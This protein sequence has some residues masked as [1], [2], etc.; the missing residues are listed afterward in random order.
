MN[1]PF[2][3][4][5]SAKPAE[6]SKSF[7]ERQGSTSS[8]LGAVPLRTVGN[9]IKGA[10]QGFNRSVA[11]VALTGINKL[12]GL[13]GQKP[14][15]FESPEGVKGFAGGLQRTV[16]G[17]EPVQDI[18]TRISRFKTEHPKISG[19]SPGTAAVTVIGSIGLDFTGLG[20]EE[21]AIKQLAKETTESGVLK[22]LTKLKVPAKDAD[23]LVK[24]LMAAKT[25]EEVNTILKGTK[26]AEGAVASEVV[27]G[28]GRRDRFRS[29]ESPAVKALVDAKV[30][31][32]TRDVVFRELFTDEATG[33]L[34]RNYYEKS[35]FKK[36]PQVIVDLDKFKDVNSKYEYQTGDAVLKR[37]AEILEK[38]FPDR[39]IRIGGEEMAVDTQ[40]LTRELVSGKLEAANAELR[41]SRFTSIKAGSEPAGTKFSG[42]SFT[43]GYGRDSGEAGE[44]LLKQKNIQRGK[45]TVDEFL[46]N[47]HNAQSV[48]RQGANIEEARPGLQAAPGGAENSGRPLRGGS[49]GIPPGDPGTPPPP[50]GKRRLINAEHFDVAPETKKAITAAAESVRPELEA[51]KGVPMSHE[52]VL[53]AA[54]DAQVLRGA[55]T[56]AQ[57]LKQE[58]ELLRL[59]QDLAAIAKRDGAGLSEQFIRDVKIVSDQGTALGRQL[60]AMKNVAAPELYANKEILIKKLLEAGVDVDRMIEAAKGVD[61]NNAQQVAEFYRTFIKPTIPEIIDEYRYINLL[62][63]PKTHITNAFSNML[64][65]TVL[66]PGTKLATG[67][68][69]MIGSAITGKARTAYASEVSPYAKGLFNSLS[70]ASGEFLKV[71]RA[72]T[73]VYRPDI[74]RIPTNLKLF[75]P[76]QVIPRLLEASD[77]FFR[78]AIRGAETEALTFRAL[79]QGKV[80]DEKLVQQIASQAETT[81]AELV[82]RKG[83]DT[84]NKTGQGHLLTSI[85]KFTSVVYQLRKVPV[86][87]WFIPFVETPMN[88]L[89]QGIE[90]S[91]LGLTTLPGAVNKTEQLAKTFVGTVVFAGAGTLA[92]EGRTTWSAPTSEKEKAAFYASGRK[93]YSVKIGD[94]W[95]SYS[96][97]GPLAYPIAMASAIAWYA[98]ENPKASTDTAEK[99]MLSIISGI[100]QFF[101][102]QSYVQG[103]GNLLDALK[104]DTTA[105]KNA[106]TNIPS[107]LVPLVSLQRWVAQII[108]PVYRKSSGDVTLQALI[109]NIQKG[110][111]FLSKGVPAELDPSGKPS[112]VQHPGVRALTPFDAGTEVPT[113]EKL[114]Q[115]IRQKQKLNA[116]KKAR[117]A[118]GKST[119]AGTLSDPFQ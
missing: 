2:A 63:S 52:E 41:S 91:P 105:I 48:S 59:R 4:K 72:E 3:T 87:K 75:K 103:M 42:I 39:V 73:A 32:E 7:M 10:W 33:A 77:V 35:G 60:E 22:L 108:D 27:A 85:D 45:I 65:A 43:G 11:S 78:T 61:F 28:S 64:Q 46:Y 68:I 89:K 6:K 81:A 97:L 94:N 95:V 53:E 67:M 25:A 119:S 90:Y 83:I 110:I 101:S 38:Y 37:Y 93:A 57:T 12:T 115:N 79:K 50:K 74:A 13:A 69:D 113:Y 18:S 31:D 34:S 106:V 51:A 44:Q 36:Q 19:L 88:I 55:T 29:V 86:V 104:G 66:R 1:D 112:Q 116:I 54:G 99:K 20:G 82:F 24:P 92:L 40:G 17:N 84:A 15:N 8:V 111:P 80:L 30:G 49:E 58:A 114:L 98:K 14:I 118:T 23:A 76:F 56:R 107:Q 16:F 47:Q 70:E 102:D 100:G 9:F 62:S 21:Q 71:M 109:Q 5:Q 96:K 26:A 117:A